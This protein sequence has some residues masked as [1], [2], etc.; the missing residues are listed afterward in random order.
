MSL[1]ERVETRNLDAARP[2]A[3]WMRPTS[4]AEFVGQDHLLGED[5]LLGRLIRADR[6][7]SVIFFGPP[8]TGKTSLAR[9]LATETRREFIQ[10]SAI[11]H[12]VKDLREVLAA[13]RDRLA[14]AGQGTLLFIDEIHRFNRAQQDALLGDVEDGVVCLVGATTANPFFAIN[15]A[16]LS[17]SQV[18]EFEA[19]SAEQIRVLVS[20]AIRNK[21]ALGSVQVEFDDG[22]I[23]YLANVCDGDARRA[24]NTLEI[25]VKSADA[26][27]VVLTRDL[28]RQSMARQM[29]AYDATG[30]DHYDSVSALIKSIR[31]SDADA[32]IYW[33]ARMLEGGEDLR[34]LCRRLVIL[35]SEDIG[36]ADP[37]A[38]ILATSCLT[39]CEQVGLPEAQLILAQTVAYL[40]VSPKSN[41]ATAAISQ[42]R[43]DIRERR[44]LPVPRALKD[45]HY[46]GASALGRGSDYRYS[47][48]ETDGV[49]AQDYL[50][51]ERHYYHPVDRGYE[52][53]IKKRL[54][55]IRQK[56]GMA[57]PKQ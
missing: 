17:R 9:I 18:F 38:L 4:L 2:L 27:Q 35:A 23:E 57:K 46:A 24:L 41:A 12:G 37:Q 1:F 47:H 28:L 49:A 6:L 10:L 14:A 22:A 43:R 13:A 52:S 11:M 5:Q 3:S 20:R 40:A 56:L 55:R 25:A 31:G 36:N 48:Q 7:G 45:S 21:T 32:G 19:L 51:V 8:G 39:A 30:D 44:V 54:E 50:G 53:Q 42:A 29:Q 26:D 34:F 16:L 15:K 33:L